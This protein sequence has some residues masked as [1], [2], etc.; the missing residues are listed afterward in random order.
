MKVLIIGNGGREHAVAHAISKSKSVSH[1]FVAP[2]YS[3]LQILKKLS[4]LNKGNGGTD[5]IEGKVSNV[6]IGYS[7]KDFPSLVNFAVENE[8]S[9]VIPGPEQPLVDGIS[10]HFKKVGIPCF[11]P[12]EKAAMLE[13]SKAFSKDFMKKHNIP[14]AEYRTFTDY[15]EAKKYVENVNH[16]VVIK[17]S[18]LAAGKGVLI[19]EN[20]KEAL[21]GLQEIMVDKIFDDAGSQV[22]VEEYLEGEEV[23]ILAISDGYTVIQ[24][25]SAQDHK[26]AFDGDKGLNTG[27]MGTYAPAPVATSDILAEIQNTVIQPTIDGM[28]RDGIPFVGCLFTGFMLT[29]S[30]PKVI[31]YNCRFGDPEIESVLSL[32]DD[33][34]DFYEVC[35]AAAEGRLDSVSL[36]FK[37]SY[38]ATVII[39]SGGYPSS[40]EK[41]KP[42]SFGELQPDVTVYHAG[43][44]K[45]DDGTIVSNGGRVLAVTGVSETLE[46]AIE[47]AYSGVSTISFED[48]FYRKDIG[49]R[50]LSKAK[51][52]KTGLTYSDSGVDIEKGNKLVDLIKPI[53]KSTRRVGTDSDIGGFGGIFDLKA[54]KF[55]DPI[56]VSA[57]DGVGTKLVIAQKMGIHDTVGIDL[58]AMQV[59]DII[60][61]GAEPLFFLDYFA[62][63]NLNLAET[64]S[65]ISGVAKGCLISGCGLIGGETAEMPALYQ[66][67]EYDVAGFAVGAVERT[68]LLPKLVGSTDVVIGM[69]SSGIHSNGFS[70]VRKI[71]EKNGLSYEDRCPWNE[72]SSVGVEL[73]TPTRIYV[74]SLLP[75]LQRERVVVKALSHITGG[76]FLDNIPRVLPEQCNV[77]IDASSWKF[78]AVFKWLKTAGNVDSSKWFLLLD[79]MARTFNCGIGMVL[80]VG[81]DD[82]EEVLGSLKS[83]G[84]EAFIIG[85]VV[86]REDYN[87]QTR[88]KMNNLSAWD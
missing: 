65:F 62:T 5:R 18:G 37:D 1:V 3:G 4:I 14:T 61:Q 32:L 12:S 83:A 87:D 48:C 74:K 6:K 27:G 46:G 34:T 33:S 39:A 59:N 44:L 2:E 10:S 11:G 67:G 54:T 58:V 29:S 8:I 75:I 23:S 56:L 53:V 64:S 19:P 40:Y 70:L 84:E 55:V 36:N 81:A 69:A 47:K 77:E 13:G 43:T 24:L 76:G 66:N 9:L 16:R 41:G 42:I 20:T 63:G 35:L 15:E 82:A 72:G 78:P 86:D 30:G 28:R 71:L 51:T 52:K 7:I 79:E 68:H 85:K 45:L 31:E 26:R 22:V 60:V 80:F 21:Q 25:P 57:T 38:A 49:H 73:L 50:A 17:A 88:V